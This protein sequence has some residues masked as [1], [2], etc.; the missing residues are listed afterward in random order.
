MAGFKETMKSAMKK[1]GKC[2]SSKSKKKGCK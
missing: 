2:K 1:V